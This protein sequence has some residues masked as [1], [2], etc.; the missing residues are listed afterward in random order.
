MIYR[1]LTLIKQTWL[2]VYHWPINKCTSY[3]KIVSL[4]VPISPAPRAAGPPTPISTTSEMSSPP[5]AGI[6]VPVPTFFVPKSSSPHTAAAPAVDLPTQAS[7]ALHLA[8]SGIRGLVLLGSTGEAVHLTRT[9][10]TEVI[11]FVRDAL[12]KAGFAGYPLIAGTASNSIEETVDML[13]DAG[14]AG[15]GWGLVLAPGFFAGAASEEGIRG[16]YEAVADRSPI[17]ILMSSFLPIHWGLL[18]LREN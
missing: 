13:S 2:P 7:H 1:N 6:Y 10:R 3:R 12:G 17:P 5:P 16:W 9:E 18:C 11:T 8:R 4:S 15:A 14:S